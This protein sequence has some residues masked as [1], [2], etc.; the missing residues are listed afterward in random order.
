MNFVRASAEANVMALQLLTRLTCS[1]PPD[2]GG[3]AA[4]CTTALISPDGW[5]HFQ[6]NFH[7]KMLTRTNLLPLETRYTTKRIKNVPICLPANP[8]Q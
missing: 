5:V 3:A 4:R 1:V 6:I 2:H 7:E 8:M